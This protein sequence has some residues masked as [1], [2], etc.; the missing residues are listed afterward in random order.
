M[1]ICMGGKFRNARYEEAESL[2]RKNK[3]GLW[4][5][6]LNLTSIKGEMDKEFKPISTIRTL[7]LLEVTNAEEF[8]LEPDNAKRPNVP[9]DPK[10]VG[11]IE[12]GGLYACKFTVDETYYRAK[13]VKEVGNK[14]HVRYID[15]GNYE[16][17]GKDRFGQLPEEMKGTKSPLYR[18]GLYGVDSVTNEG[19][20]ILKDCI[21]AELKVEFKEELVPQ[22]PK[23]EMEYRV[24]LSE[25]GECINLE[26]IQLG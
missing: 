6:N 11:P 8:Y 16:T 12:V 1:A 10:P 5:Y 15:F 9:Q 26:L 23:D 25:K 20:N 7:T 13:V 2:A 14:Y 17:I 3:I 24:V 22:G 18:C 4:K 19:L 21:G